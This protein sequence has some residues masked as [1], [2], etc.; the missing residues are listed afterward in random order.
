MTIAPDTRIG[1]LLQEYPELLEVLADYA[2]AFA[3]LRNP[4]LRRVIGRMA[5]LAQAASMGGVDLPEL[6]Q[7][8]RKAAGEP[9]SA[10]DEAA[11]TL[12]QMPLS[13]ATP[14]PPQWL[15]ETRVAA[16]FD[17]RPL[18]VEG[19]NPIAPILKAA[20]DVPVGHIF[21]LRNTFEPLPL[22]EVLGEQGLIPWARSHGPDDWDVFFYRTRPGEEVGPHPGS[23]AESGAPPVASVSIDVSQLTPPEPMM[24]VLEALAQLQP[25][26]TLLV[27][28]VQ[29]PMYLYRK[30]DDKGHAHQTWEM[31]PGHVEILIRVGEKK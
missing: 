16:R 29:R 9:A 11:T 23:A 27:R 1:D 10:P 28:H 22:Y 31:G 30:L 7:T 5:T 4:L 6:L 12:A 20:Q 25:G 26:D 21:H 14:E 18:H 24:R 2:P 13:A 19:R 3:K 8:L 17:A 15:D